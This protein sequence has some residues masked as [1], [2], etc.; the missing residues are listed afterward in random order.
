[1]SCVN[2]VSVAN[3]CKYE[4]HFSNLT[5]NCPTRWSLSFIFV[6]LCWSYFTTQITEKYS[7]AMCPLHHR[8]CIGR[9]AKPPSLIIETEPCAGNGVDQMATT[10]NYTFVVG[11]ASSLQTIQYWVGYLWR[12]ETRSKLK[13][14]LPRPVWVIMI[15]C[16]VDS[17]SARDPPP[18][19]LD[20]V[21]NT[22]RFLTPQRAILRDAMKGWGFPQT[23][24]LLANHPFIKN[25][26]TVF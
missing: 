15:W 14:F 7:T 22:R 18:R 1:M 13:V 6:F 21:Q 8:P 5:V 16:E 19:R 12:G 2:S 23:P 4:Q 10:T 25:I 17:L 20:K 24:L 11:S 26:W 9:S 3:M